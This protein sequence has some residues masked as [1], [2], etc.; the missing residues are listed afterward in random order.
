M[1][2][3]CKS[4]DTTDAT[5]V[6][7][8]ARIEGE[9][10]TEAELFVPYP[11]ATEDELHS[12]AGAAVP[13]QGSHRPPAGA[14]IRSALT[15]VIEPDDGAPPEGQRA[16]GKT[17]LPLPPEASPEPPGRV[18]RGVRYI[19]DDTDRHKLDI[20]IPPGEQA[21]PRAVIIHFH[22]GGWVR[23]DRDNAFYGAP[24]MCCGYAERGFVAVAPSYRLS[25]APQHMEDAAQAVEW[26]MQHI[27]T[28]GGDPEEVYLSGHSAGGN[29]CSLLVLGRWLVINTREL[30]CTEFS[31]TGLFVAV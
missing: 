25:S 4:T 5:L 6:A 24:A 7:D 19:E 28:F 23:G 13:L 21:V 10:S 16:P 18:H 2:N 31:V 20:F 3:S 27:P 9:T 12:P 11:E 1:G 26:V 30:A 29:I 17:R 14:D 22:G 15:Q 8:L